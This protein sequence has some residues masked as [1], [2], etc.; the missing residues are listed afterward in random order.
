MRGWRKE[1]AGNGT[2]GQASSIL[3]GMDADSPR[4]RVPFFLLGFVAL[5]WLDGW[6]VLADARAQTPLANALLLVAGGILGWLLLRIPVFSWLLPADWR[7]T[8]QAAFVLGLSIALVSQL[9]TWLPYQDL[10]V[11][12]RRMLDPPWLPLLHLFVLYP[13]LL[14]SLPMPKMPSRPGVWLGLLVAANFGFFWWLDGQSQAAAERTIQQPLGSASAP[15]KPNVVLLVFDT[16]RGDTIHQTWHKQAHMPWL[17]QY[18]AQARVFPYGFAGANL[19][20][21]GHATLLT[22]R[23]PA[24]NGTLPK[25][26]VAM[27][28][29]ELSLAE[30]LRGYGYRT[31][32]T[33]TNARITRSM[34]FGQGFEVYDDGLVANEN[35]LFTAINRCAW[36]SLMTMFGG[37][38]ARRAT[39]AIAKHLFRQAQLDLSAADTTP[40]ALAA[41]DRLQRKAE[42]PLFLFVNYIDPHFPYSTRPDL[43]EA[44]GPNIRNEA[45]EAIRDNSLMMHNLMR[46]MGDAIGKGEA[47]DDM[48][49]RLEWLQEAYREQFRELDEGVQALFAGLEQ[50]GITRENSLILITSDHGEHLG[51]HGIMMHGRSLFQDEVHVPFLLLGPGVEPAVVEDAVSGVDFFATVLHGMGLEQTTV[52]GLMGVPLQEPI[53]SRMVRFESGRLRGVVMGKHKMIADDDGTQLTWVEAY[54]LASDPGELHNL[55]DSGLDWVEAVKNQPPIQPSASAVEVVAGSGKV[56]LAALGYVDEGS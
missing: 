11:V 5:L 14:R 55:I 37:K 4:S 25:G 15:A 17:D 19:T 22:G 40:R 54:D 13:L 52:D 51:A 50:R 28:Q 24:E 7:H 16:M 34:G 30:F 41:M 26:E 2:G 49:A 44:F 21:G 31:A 33:V 10:P 29:R 20:P 32:A 48:D 56:D 36:S 8:P 47:V 6:Q 27:P 9:P 45:M 3:G 42:E 39:T 35:P 43:A 38:K 1:I 18:T 46:H 23:Y 53:P 12:V